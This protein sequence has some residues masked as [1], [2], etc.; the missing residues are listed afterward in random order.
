MFKTSALNHWPILV[1]IR[2]TQHRYF[3]FLLIFIF[4]FLMI[5]LSFLLFILWKVVAFFFFFILVCFFLSLGGGICFA[6]QRLCRENALHQHT[7]GFTKVFSKTCQDLISLTF[8]PTTVFSA[9]T[10]LQRSIGV[11]VYG[12]CGTLQ[13]GNPR[14]M[15]HKYRSSC[16]TASCNSLVRLAIPPTES[17]KIFS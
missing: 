1:G 16:L 5:F 7:S 6:L 10:F 2:Q 17:D 11:D 9:L 4:G 14:N 15:G 3:Y 13:C 12:D 8:C